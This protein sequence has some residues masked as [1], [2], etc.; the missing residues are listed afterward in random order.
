MSFAP[1]STALARA[2]FLGASLAAATLLLARPAAA[3]NEPTFAFGKPEE[4]KPQAPAVEWKVQAKGGPEPD[5]GQLPDHEC[6]RRA[7]RLSQ[8]GEQQA[9]PRRRH[10]LRPLQHPGRDNRH[11][12]DAERDHGAEPAG[13]DVDEQLVQQ[14]PLRSLLHRRTTRVTSRGRPPPTRSPARPSRAAA[15][16]VTAAS[17]S[18][19]TSNMLVAEL[20]YDFSYESYVEQ[21]GKTLDPV[22]IHSARVVRR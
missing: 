16:S 12:D 6:D 5:V 21:P 15:R 13:G 11:D 4:V 8:G 1:R 10:Q 17:S 3:Q 22:S 9:R 2:P 7:D 20:G 19:P 18:R 14:G